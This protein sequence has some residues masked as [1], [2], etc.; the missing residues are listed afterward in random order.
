MQR[1]SAG[2]A[3]IVVATLAAGCAVR[4]GIPASASP[5]AVPAWTTTAPGLTP[6]VSGDLSSWWTHLGDAT[7]TSLIEQAVAESPT[8][9]LARA[10]L[11]QARAQQAQATAEL[12]PTISGSG[13]ASGRR[14][15][16]RVF[17]PDGSQTV[18]N[19]VFTGSYGASLDA[20]WEPD[21][22]GTTRRGI[23]AARVDTAAAA[24]DLQSTRVSL[25]AEVALSYAELRALQERL[26]IARRN[27]ASQAET[28]ELTGFR[29]QA[30]LVSSVDA[31]Q[32]RANLEQ[33]RAQLPTL[34]ASIRHATFRL[35]TLT[36]AAAG[37][38]TPMLEQP[39]PLPPVPAEIAVGIPAETL[40]QRPD[41]RA[42]ELRVVA[43]TTRLA[44][45]GLRRYPRFS[46]SGTVGLEV[47]T[48]AMTGGTNT[49]ASVA[50]ALAQTLFDGGRIRQQIAIQNAVQEQAV[51][52]YESTVLTALE[53]VERALVSFAASRQRLASLQAATSAAESAATLARSQYGA[54]LA[55]FQTVL[56]TERSVL[57]LQD[58]IAQTSGDRLSALVQ[59]YKA[60]GG[61]WSPDALISPS[62]DGPSS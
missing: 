54:G 53:D 30:G 40:R 2:L 1:L 26:A 56:N 15:G 8:I 32:A 4:A 16:T 5:A 28:L 52:S 42:A 29:V 58:G 7:L 25:A 10:R 51:A 36:G 31:E 11:R 55:D 39:A 20:S 60:L 33:T 17:S 41:V 24:A 48:G 38:L 27:E 46:L 23:E 47:L 34:Q 9:E 43:E 6:T 21:V 22:F 19:N 49:V 18:A 13:S 37:F 59:L 35:A 62:S 50:A 44:Q 45:A 57:T 14:S 12:W 3:P 61:G